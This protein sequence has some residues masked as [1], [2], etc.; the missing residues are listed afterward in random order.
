[1]WLRFAGGFITFAEQ[2]EICYNYIHPKQG[3]VFL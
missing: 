1:M 3:M 2:I